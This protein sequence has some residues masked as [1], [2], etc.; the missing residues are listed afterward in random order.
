MVPSNICCHFTFKEIQ[1]AT[2]NFDES[3]LLGKGGFGNVYSGMMDRGIKVAIKR[4]NPLS[5]QG[6]HEFRTEIET[7]SLLRHRHLVSLI[8]YCEENNEMILVY[9]YMASGTL[10][11]HLYNTKRSPLPWKQRLDICIGAAQGLHYLHSGA[12]QTIIHRDVKTANILLDDKLAAKVSDFGLSKASLDINDT[13]VSTVVKG[14]FGYLDPEYFRR[15]QLTQKSDVYSFGVV[16]FEVLCARPVVNTELPDEQVSLRD[17]ALSCQNKETAERCVADRS[18]DRPQMGDVLQNLQIALQLQ[19]STGDYKSYAEA[20]SSL[21]KICV[22]PANPSTDTTMSVAGQGAVYSD[23]AHTEEVVQTPSAFYICRAPPPL[24]LGLSRAAPYHLLV[25]IR[26]PHR[27]LLLL[28]PPLRLLLLLRLPPHLLLPSPPLGRVVF[29]PPLSGN[30]ASVAV[31][32]EGSTPVEGAVVPPS[33]SALMD[34]LRQAGAD[35]ADGADAKQATG[36]EAAV[37]LGQ[38]PAPL[39]RAP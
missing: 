39:D 23:I 6:L 3:F 28:R 21:V 16:L 27:L 2:S 11:E 9:D 34:T 30:G 20:A 12:K 10:R 22:D 8:G 33:P 37:R 4:G 17:W 7:L 26:P 14:T 38:D 19:E 18:M 1:A 36:S 29:S 24:G 5:Q 32:A 31:A 13:H 25:L 35:T 15:K